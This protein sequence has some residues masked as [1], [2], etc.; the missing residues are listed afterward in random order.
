MKIDDAAFAL[1][2]ARRVRVRARAAKHGED[3]RERRVALFGGSGEGNVQDGRFVD[4]GVDGL[5]VI[6]AWDF[7]PGVLILAGLFTLV[8]VATAAVIAAP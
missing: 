4:D 1:V 8:K 6:V 2:W 7:T 3:N 5:I